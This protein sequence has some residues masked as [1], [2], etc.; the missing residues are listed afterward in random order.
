[1]KQKHVFASCD[2][3]Y[4]RKRPMNNSVASLSLANLCSDLLYIQRV[5]GGCGSTSRNPWIV[6]RVN[7]Y[8]WTMM[9]ITWRYSFLFTKLWVVYYIFIRISVRNKFHHSVLSIRHLF[10]LWHE[11][12]AHLILLLFLPIPG[13]WD[14]LST[15][16]I[17][18]MF[19]AKYC[20]ITMIAEMT[21]SI[22]WQTSLVTIYVSNGHA[23]VE[24][25]LYVNPSK[26]SCGSYIHSRIN[27]NPTLCT[28]GDPYWLGQAGTMYTCG[29]IIKD[30]N[31]LT[32]QMIEFAC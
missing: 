7:S 24:S 11:G 1:M 3:D 16:T 29:I 6:D 27:A 12:T 9:I 18:K 15:M 19:S 23:A 28:S 8:I 21:F 31:M 22:E 13:E 26:T 5:G 30:G 17:L 20:T 25:L 10:K 4:H 32:G 14:N 2:N